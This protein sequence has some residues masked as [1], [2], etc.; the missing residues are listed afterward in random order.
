MTNDYGIDEKK[1]DEMFNRVRSMEL[2][3]AR[4][5]EKSDK[6]M[7]DEIASYLLKMRKGADYENRKNKTL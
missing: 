3:N 2:R 4:N 5:N 6:K 7:V 1:F